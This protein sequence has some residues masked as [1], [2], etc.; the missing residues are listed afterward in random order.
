M[1]VQGG[2][3]IFVLIIN[4][5]GYDWKPKEMTIGL[6]EAIKTTSQI[7]AN[8]LTKL[9]DPYGLRKKIFT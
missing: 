2:H 1:D 7:L 6:Y 3:D 5:L 9:L 4:F 8:N